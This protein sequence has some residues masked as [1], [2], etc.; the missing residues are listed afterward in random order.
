MLIAAI[1]TTGLVAG[2]FFGFA[3]AVMPGLRRVDD[4]AFVAVMQAI[5]VRILNGAFLV[6]FVGAPLLTAGALVVALVGE[7]DRVGP[8]AVAVVLTAVSYLIT[9]M[10]NVPL[11]TS[12]DPAAGLGGRIEA[13]VV[14]A[15]FEDRWV[16][17]NIARTLASTGAFGALLWAL[18]IS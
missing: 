3:C 13:T 4:V 5:N 2:L 15:E 16:R 14:R 10:V 11:N 7:P 18:S 8:I 12:L 17:S 9:A 6:C 1:V